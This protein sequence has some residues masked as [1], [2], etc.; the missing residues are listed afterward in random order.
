MIN[1]GIQK[2][3]YIETEDNTLTELKSCFQSFLLR[4]F[5][6]HEH[7]KKMYPKSNQPAKLYA[8]AKMHK[9]Q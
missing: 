1:D 6:K 5:S 3:I 9:F 7:Y 4:N 8:T 2:E